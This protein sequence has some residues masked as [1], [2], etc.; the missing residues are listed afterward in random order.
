MTR[1]PARAPS[2]ERVHG[3]APFHHGGT[4]SVLSAPGVHGAAAPLRIDGAVNSELFAL[5]VAHRLVPRLRPGHMV[6]LGDVTFHYS[7][8]AIALIEEA[9]A[10]GGHLPAYSPDL[11][12]LEEGAAKSKAPLRSLKARTKSTL[13]TA[14]AKALASV[15]EREIRGWLKHCG[16]VCS[17]K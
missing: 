8:R 13:S 12:P 11:N 15:T 14:L 5:Y 3:T 17:L 7:P 1:T 10:R 4:I 2:G 16:Y 9:G 6:L